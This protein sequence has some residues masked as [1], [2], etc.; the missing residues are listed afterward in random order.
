MRYD[1]NWYK[2][3]NKPDFV[4]PDWVFPVVW[5]ILYVF[6]VAAFLIVIFSPFRL[7]TFFADLFFVVQLIF[8]ISWAPVFFKEHD[9]RKAFL[10]SA[11]LTVFVFLTMII[12]FNISIIAGILFIPYFLWCIFATIICFEVLERNEW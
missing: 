10:I 8:N 3:L 9:L 6:M 1:E 12:F 5:P 2:N 4:P 7:I 11:L